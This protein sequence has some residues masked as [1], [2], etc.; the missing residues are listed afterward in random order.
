MKNVYLVPWWTVFCSFTDP[1]LICIDGSSSTYSI[2][3]SV[4]PFNVQGLNSSNTWILLS[5]VGGDAPS[6][7][8]FLDVVQPMNNPTGQ[9]PCQ[10]ASSTPSSSGR[11]FD[12]LCQCYFRF[13]SFDWSYPDY[14]S[15]SV[16]YTIC[17]LSESGFHLQ[18]LNYCFQRLFCTECKTLGR[19]SFH[20]LH[21]LKSVF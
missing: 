11:F 3:H 8:F 6:Y 18:M 9:R 20:I 5:Y 19:T 17:Q 16:S 15:T 1:A 13:H 7:L 4:S 12:L 10:F 2:T 21:Q 14:L